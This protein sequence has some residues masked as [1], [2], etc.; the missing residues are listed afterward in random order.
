MEHSHQPT[1]PDSQPHKQNSDQSLN[2][3]LNPLETVRQT[4]RIATLA[5]KDV[6]ALQR[7]IGNRAVRSLLA[8]PPNR[9]QAKWGGTDT[10]L[11]YTNSMG[12]QNLQLVNNMPG[13][14]YGAPEFAPL[15][16]SAQLK[17]YMAN[18]VNNKY[19][20]PLYSRN[21]L[22]S[23]GPAGADW[24]CYTVNPDGTYLKE[25]FDRNWAAV[26]QAENLDSGLQPIEE[27]VYDVPD[28]GPAPRRQMVAATHGGGRMFR[29]NKPNDI[30]ACNTLIEHFPYDSVGRQV[31]AGTLVYVT[32]FNKKKFHLAAGAV[33]VD[34]SGVGLDNSKYTGL[35]I[36]LQGINQQQN[37]RGTQVNVVRFAL[38]W[39]GETAASLNVQAD[40]DFGAAYLQE[41]LTESMNDQLNG[42]VYLD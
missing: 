39:D 3:P 1:G 11:M 23:P 7:A 14:L 9:V 30:L 36:D 35:R 21:A 28:V 12:A 31:G 2:E 27:I 20:M 17:V 32:G 29:P 18:G 41:S 37:D 13:I 15:S 4:R 24:V 19:Y 5:P 40:K 38:Q 8:A 42:H 26:G 10:Q 34:L 25:F 33:E 16:S 22:Q 6:L